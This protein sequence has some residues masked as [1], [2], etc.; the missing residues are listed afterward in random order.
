[1]NNQLSSLEG[2]C[3][4]HLVWLSWVIDIFF[5]PTFADFNV[6]FE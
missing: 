3:L 4:E 6:F 5:F 1:M 2:K